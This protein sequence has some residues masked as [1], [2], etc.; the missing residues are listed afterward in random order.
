MPKIAVI[1]GAGFSKPC[2]LP[3]SRDLFSEPELPQAPRPYHL[4]LFQRVKS[5]FESWRQANGTSDAEVWLGHLY[6]TRGPLQE[7]LEGITWDDAI[8]YALARLVKLRKR[9]A[10]EPY[11]H[12]ITTSSNCPSHQQFWQRLL[13]TKSLS[14]VVSMNY[15]I[16]AEQ[17]LR[18]SYGK[19]RT[20]PICYYGGYQ[21]TQV[22]RK[23]TN[24]AKGEVERYSWG[25][26]SLSIRCMVRLT[27]LGRNI[28]ER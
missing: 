20:A 26:R 27:G 21:Y 11:Y 10:K 4:Q 7:M 16:L 12:G 5:V 22:V 6:S 24:L 23:Y 8:S 15:D 28:V 17:G 9:G 14:C 19:E 18:R 3:L 25:T 1:L 2:G 13:E